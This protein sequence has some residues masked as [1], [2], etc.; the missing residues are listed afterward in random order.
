MQMKPLQPLKWSEPLHL[1]ADDHAQII[2]QTGLIQPMDI[3]GVRVNKYAE[4]DGYIS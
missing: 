3:L 2:Q 4:W 1:A